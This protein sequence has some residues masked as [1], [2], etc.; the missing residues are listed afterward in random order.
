MSVW[1]RV[2]HPITHHF[3]RRCGRFLLAQFPGIRSARICDLGGSR[4]FRDKL[5]LNDPREHIT[6][7]NI[8]SDETQGPDSASDG[9]IRL[10]I[11]D[12]KHIPVA[13]R[14]FDLL[15][16]NSVLEHL[17][18][19]QRADLATEMRRVAKALFPNATLK[20][21]RMFGLIKSYYAIETNSR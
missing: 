11:Y 18:P 2:I 7:Y 9:G 4:H 1:H 8:S 20:T 17:P 19:A 3:R 21:E 10:L 13:D 6:I 5:E 12:G 16:C 15:I 14:A